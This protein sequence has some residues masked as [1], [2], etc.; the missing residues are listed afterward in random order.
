MRRILSSVALGLALLC[1]GIAWA[2]FT[3]RSTLFDPA[4]SE[5]IATVLVDSPVVRD[6]A[7]DALTAALAKALPPDA[8][9]SSAEIEAAARA[10]LADP[11]ASAAL[12]TAV[13]GTH[14][15][16]VGAG[17]AGPV[18]L[19]AG[20]IA[21]AGRDALIAARPD[22][23]RLLPAA[24]E[25]Q[26]ALPTERLPD[27]G[28][29]RGPLRTASGLGA[30]AAALLTALALLLAADRPRVLSRLGRW[31]FGAGLWWS[32]VGYGLPR[33]VANSGDERLGLLGGL[34]TAISGPVVAPA[35]ALSL[36]GAAI[37]LGSRLWRQSLAAAGTAAAPA[38]SAAG[39]VARPGE[40]DLD[41]RWDRRRP[42][43]RRP[44]SDLDAAARYYTGTG[45]RRD[46]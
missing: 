16:M 38:A 2:A 41:R 11:R 20:P 30:A 45:G 6:A 15:R 3:T 9:V 46:T 31:A 8:P 23:A 43:Y 39:A 18:T 1:A 13:V 40:A 19:D 34:G 12:R 29:F 14:R 32:I 26:V 22:L 27:L 25:L 5:R 44:Q 42:V 21:A 37:M 7:A 17:E 33:L 36:I 28:G 35:L 10:A 24:P 4:R